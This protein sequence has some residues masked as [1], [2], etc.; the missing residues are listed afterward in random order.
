MIGV[1]E[2]LEDFI[3]PATPDSR[4]HLYVAWGCPFCHRVM[5]A[6]A[7][8]RLADR[9]TYTW[10][11]NIK[12]P[13][14]WD[15]EPGEDPLLGATSLEQVYKH[16]EPDRALRP[17]VPLLVDLSTR[18][19]LST[20]SSAMTRYFS[21]GM[22]GAYLVA[23]E[24]SPRPLVDQIDQ[25]NAW[26]HDNVNRAVYRVGFANAQED[27]EHKVAA[28][29]ESLD[30]LDA[31]LA[32]QPYLL[33]DIV[34]ESDLYLL[35]TLVRFDSVYFPLFRCSYRR[36]AD[37]S[38]LS[39]YMDRLMKMDGL[40]RTYDHVRTR[41]HYFCSVMHIDGNIVDFNPSRIIPADPPELREALRFP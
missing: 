30:E 38:A 3:P 17:S 16:L 12:G 28:L 4:L 36:I 40:A 22:N 15:I 24:L 33:G 34:T 14:G 27:Y 1:T 20:S 37:Y 35:A 13:S 39:A 7:M 5:A 31:R 21:L 9:V 23:R 19:L 8:T 10:M 32:A 2:R 29:F 18:R 41:Q 25:M 26:L 6:L 11:R